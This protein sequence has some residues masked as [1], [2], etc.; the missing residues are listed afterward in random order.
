MDKLKELLKE[1]D[2]KSSNPLLRP[3]RTM[4]DAEELI[5]ALRVE[6]DETQHA[7]DCMTTTASELQDMWNYLD[8][9]NKASEKL[10]QIAIAGKEE[11]IRVLRKDVKFYKEEPSDV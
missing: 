9:A 3:H 10:H 8:A 6:L 2:E 11:V 5:D 4:N 1:W 7:L